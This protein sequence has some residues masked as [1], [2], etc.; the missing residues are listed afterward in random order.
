MFIFKFKFVVDF[1]V[2]IPSRKIQPPEPEKTPIPTAQSILAATQMNTST[3]DTNLSAS[4]ER[5][6]TDPQQLQ[7]QLQDL[8]AT[9]VGFS[10]AEGG[11][12][13]DRF[14]VIVFT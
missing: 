4:G 5:A 11:E 8:L 6:T 9:L 14:V 3:S 1:V 12:Q 10:A 13:R 7:A 2:V